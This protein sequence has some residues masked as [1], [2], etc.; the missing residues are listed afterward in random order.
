VKQVTQKLSFHLNAVCCFNN[1]W[2]IDMWPADS[3]TM[4]NNWLCALDGR[5]HSTLPSVTTCLT[6]IKSVM[7]SVT[8]LKNGSCSCQVLS[9]SQQT[10]LMGYLTIS[11]NVRCYQAHCGWQFCLSA[12][13]CTVQ[14]LQCKI[15]DF[16]VSYDALNSPELNP[17]VTRLGKS[18][19]RVSMNCESTGVKKSSSWSLAT[20]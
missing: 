13:E 2:H 3:W 17:L 16:L 1:T 12:R 19:S 5:Q 7:V 10:V 8:V 4:Q 6:F 14:L 20:Q 15:L 18:C 9:E 11:T